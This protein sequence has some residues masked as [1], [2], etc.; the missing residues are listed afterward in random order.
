MRGVE[1]PLGQ[2]AGPSRVKDGMKSESAWKTKHHE[3]LYLFHKLASIEDFS[4]FL[5]FNAQRNQIQGVLGFDLFS[6]CF[7]TLG[8]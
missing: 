5:N 1:A 6:K 8:Q 7:S 3:S 4:F 2:A